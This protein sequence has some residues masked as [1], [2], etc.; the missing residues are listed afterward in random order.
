M[1]RRRLRRINPLVVLG[2]NLLV[3][4]AYLFHHQQP[5]VLDDVACQLLL[6]DVLAFYVEPEVLA[7]QATAVGEVHLEIELHPSVRG[8][9]FHRPPQSSQT[10]YDIHSTSRRGI[11]RTS[12]T[13]FSELR[14]VRL[15]AG[16]VPHAGGGQDLRVHQAHVDAHHVDP[17]IHGDPVRDTAALPTAVGLEGLIAPNVDVGGRIGGEHAHPLR[18][19]VGPQGAVTPAYRAMAIIHF[20]RRGIDLQADGT[21]MTRSFYHLSPTT[22]LLNRGTNLIYDSALRS[23]PRTAIQRS[24]WKEDSPKFVCRIVHRRPSE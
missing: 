18:R 3:E 17:G 24:A 2:D 8:V 6:G 15:G 21:A 9:F 1:A 10:S 5:H 22:P 19:V 23:A 13:E 14:G 7:L 4:D 20:H 16:G 11:P 12:C